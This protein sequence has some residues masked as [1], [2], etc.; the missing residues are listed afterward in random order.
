MPKPTSVA[1]D[2]P[3]K[4]VVV[5]LDSHLAG[6]V[7]RARPLLQ[8]EIPGLSLRL[9]AAAEWDD[10]PQLLERCREDIASGDIIIASMLFMDDHI[11]AVLPALQERR[12]RC[13]A[14]VGCM[15]G[16]EVM[17]LTRMGK[18]AMDG[19][20][21]GPMALLKRLR[22]K[23][24]GT[25]KNASSGAGQM[26][27][28]RRIPKILRFIPG[29]AQDV[30]AYFLVL[31][32]WLA[33]SDENIA[34]MVRHLVDRYAD[35]AR[36]SLRGRL[37]VAAPAEYPDVGLFHPRM[38][39]RITD[40]ISKLPA[41]KGST[42][43]VGLLVM[44]SYVLA[45]NT[46]HYDGVIKALEAR[47]LRVVPAFASGL[48]ARP[49]I[50]RFFFDHGS[51]SVDAVVSLTGFSL[52]GGPAYNDSA[53]AQELLAKLDVPYLAAHPVEFQTLEQWG[54]SERG[55]MPVEATMM[56]AI[57][58]LDGSTGPMVFGGRSGEA[59]E[60]RSRDMQSHAERANMLAARVE[61]LVVLRRTPVQERKVAAVLFNFPPN[62]GNT[63]T[64]A[65]LSVFASLHRTLQAMK[66]E[67]YSVEVPD[68]VDELRDRIIG[69]NGS[70]YGAHANVFTR[71][72]SDDHVRREPYLAEIESQWGPAPGKQ[73]SDGASIFVCGEQ[74]GN[75]F[76]GV[77]PSFGYEGDP[78]RLLFDKGFTPTHAFSAFYRFLREDFGANAVLHFGTH[79]ALEFMPG[80]QA[81]LSGACWP[82]R[83][84]SDLPNMY[85]YASNNPSEG[86]IAK[87]RAA[88]TLV[89][90]LTPPI[91]NAGLYRGLV[92]LK[93]SIERWR[94][95][96]PDAPAEERKELAALIQAQAAELDLVPLASETEPEWDADSG[97]RVQR[98][99]DEILE[100]EYTLI[101]H[102]LHVVGEPPN[103]E[104]RVDLL[105]AVA[106]SKVDASEPVPLKRE[107]VQTLIEGG[108]PTLALQKGGM[109]VN[110]A[111]LALMSQLA[112]YNKLL[113]EDY[114]TPAILRALAGRFVRP[115]PGGDLLRSPEILPTGRNLHGFDPFR[116]PSVF[117]MKEGTRHAQLLL[118]RYLEDGNPL[119][120]SVAL[121]LWGTDNLKT[122]GGP[123]AQALALIGAEPRLDSY[124][125]VCGAQLLPLDK[126]GRAR[127][128]VVMT[129][130][131][132]FRDLLPL[133]TK[134]LAEA[135]F[136]AATADEP[137]EMNFVR[138]HALAYQKAHDCDIETAALRVFS[139]ADGAY[140]SNVNHLIDNSGWDD[141]DELAETYTRR[142]CF[143]YGRSG[144]PVRQADLLKSVL[145]DVQLAYQNLD[146]VELGVTTVDHYFDTL[147]GIS[148]A[149]TRSKGSDV[150]VYIGDQTRGDGKVRTLAEQVALET[151][152]RMLN[153]KWYEGM[154]KHGYEGVRQIEVH[155][156][157]TM[158]WSATTGQ[159]APWVYQ[160]MTETFV[161][162]EEMRER[163]AALNPTASAKV[164]SR[165]IEAHERNYWTPDEATLE[166]LR[167]AGE[168]L[169]DRLEG[170]TEGVAA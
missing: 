26:A 54:S 2:I 151:R 160:R 20:Q 153:P 1:E 80:K 125:R 17:R 13:D 77:Q 119:P 114:E 40:Q 135:S 74:F 81:G 168:E 126:L 124:G 91:A 139:N 39:G 140:G 170:I 162:D 82:D 66:R 106:E 67:G 130:S 109:E 90:Y 75:V 138:K 5:T 28:L 79:G 85:L 12:D 8:K 104:E 163:L 32:Y 169:E 118:E 101:P 19:S 107:T 84:I 29:T 105:M 129:L 70:R 133:Q 166:A 122:E 132:I 73:Q 161:L 16:G 121:V 147:G 152:T 22:G 11:K 144:I 134:L 72:P 88:A 53:A 55:L 96:T 35:G 31:Q 24:K 98:L 167:R 44:R 137:E 68:S 15:S 71:I 36:A 103:D 61:R 49:A 43:T 131:G 69:G 57:P 128:D 38:K 3:V 110:D 83:L 150:P 92:D 89:S 97:E 42:G 123:I 25:D 76:V 145:G 95:L 158:G 62:A 111:N 46:G 136:L 47:G 112:E 23:S 93:A 78:M 18:F 120:E 100:L 94:G 51:A 6:A 21:S 154:L 56:V 65:Y 33:G 116:L 141:E 58:E 59:T 37:K 4:V 14:M 142:K 115:A 127:I 7:E 50:E 41:K 86:T 10:D 143:A 9:H 52:V 34:N 108:A 64:A 146:S 102:G 48:D 149:V 165:L 155:V 148:R 60:D 87:R 99:N 113:S 164:A 156:T 45:G 30:R 159:V 157:N 63:G 27:M 117:A